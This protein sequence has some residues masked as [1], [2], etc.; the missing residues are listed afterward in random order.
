MTRILLIIVVATFA[1]LACRDETAEVPVPEVAVV[2]SEPVQD[3]ET[4]QYVFM[5][6]G[7]L[8]VLNMQGSTAY[9]EGK[10]LSGVACA[11]YPKDVAQNV[12]FKAVYK[13]GLP[14]GLM[15]TYDMQGKLTL[16]TMY[17]KGLKQGTERGFAGG[18]VISEATYKDGVLDGVAK[19]YYPHKALESVG[20][21]VNGKKDGTEQMYTDRGI[22]TEEAAYK[23]GVKQGVRK[24]Y[25]VG[26][27]VLELEMSYSNG[28]LDGA[29]KKYGDDGK[30][31][32]NVFLIDGAAVSGTCGDSAS[33]VANMHGRLFW[34]SMLAE[35]NAGNSDEVCV[36]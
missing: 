21:Y 1:L 24:S 4:C 12:S 26:T 20:T 17:S 7:A 35:V 6:D 31:I 25:Y 5:D 19:T 33:V 27:G 32:Y 36:K 2:D 23:N 18:T 9:F 16:E 29:Y 30:L 8:P 11:W 22:L 13:D 14:D 15:R 10:P 34:S 3:T 28:E